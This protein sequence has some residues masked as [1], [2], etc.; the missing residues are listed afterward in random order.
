MELCIAYIFVLGI[1]E[2]GVVVSLV[3]GFGESGESE[4]YFYRS[5]SSFRTNILPNLL[6][7]CNF[8]N[9]WNARKFR[10]SFR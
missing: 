6:H 1:R 10:L 3:G 4:G 7:S 9:G 2:F 8:Q 5:A